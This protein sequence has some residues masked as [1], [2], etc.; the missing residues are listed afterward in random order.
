MID[1]HWF[2]SIDCDEF[3]VT[4]SKT[5]QLPCIINV[6]HRIYFDGEDDFYVSETSFDIDDGS[7]LPTLKLDRDRPLNA[8]ELRYF[9]KER[10][11]NGWKLSG[12]TYESGSESFEEWCKKH[13]LPF[14]EEK[15]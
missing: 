4:L 5:T 12:G 1:H 11:D 7:C 2:M 15:P 8:V 10:I 3:G 9:V 14:V 13:E 6:D